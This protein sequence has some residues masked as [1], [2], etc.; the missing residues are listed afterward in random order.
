MGEFPAT[1]FGELFDQT[2][3]LPWEQWLPVDAA[4]PVRGRSVR[5]QL[6][7]VPDC[8]KIVKK[9]V[10]ERLKKSH[11]RSWFDETGP[12]FP[13]DI[14][15]LNDHCTLTLDTTGPGLHKRGYR[16]LT[17]TAPLKETL[18]AALVQLSYWNPRRRLIDPCCGTGTILIEAAL[19]GRNIA[20]GLDRNFHAESWPR[21]PPSDWRAARE[22]ARDVM[23]PQLEERL[24][25]FDI[26][27]RPLA[28]ARTA[29]QLA[30]VFDDIHFQQRPL[31][32]FASPHQ[33]GVIICNPP[34]GERIGT[35]DAA[36]ALYREMGTVFQALETWSI[37][38]LTSHA[39]FER[40]Y[41]KRAQRRRKLFNG[42]LACTYYQYPGPPPSREK[43][44]RRQA[45]APGDSNRVD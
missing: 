7:S 27:D 3:A 32:R 45:D 1:D 23:L 43:R 10:V 5:S 22:Q 38:L 9:A 42:R 12:L 2:T 34:Y 17:G 18:A 33:Y 6:H 21:I 44:S 35:R 15:L 24:S 26:D 4:F 19:I 39:E 8:Q 37:Y 25:G 29:A 31:A 13:I 30:G 20:P 14:H 11:A 41:G 28:L 40:L 36:E 16:K